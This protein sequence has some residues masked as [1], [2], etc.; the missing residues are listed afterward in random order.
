MLT[1]EEQHRGDYDWP[2]PERSDID[3]K[4]LQIIYYLGSN[5]KVNYPHGGMDIQAFPFQ[6][7]P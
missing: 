2:W 7:C 3:E 5:R 6:E 4:D 1:F